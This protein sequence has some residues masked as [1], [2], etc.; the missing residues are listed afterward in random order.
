MQIGRTDENVIEELKMSSGTA[1]NP[2]LDD[3]V[4]LQEGRMRQTYH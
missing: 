2:Q 1:A 3:Y 4:D